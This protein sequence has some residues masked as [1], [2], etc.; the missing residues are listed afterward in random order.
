MYLSLAGTLVRVTGAR[1]RLAES[2]GEVFA[3]LLVPARRGRRASLLVRLAGGPAGITVG[4]GSDTVQAAGTGHAVAL[5]EH[6]LFSRWARRDSRHL[7]L[8]AAAVARRVRALLLVGEK[9][10][11][12][13]TLAAALVQRGL[14][15]GGDETVPLRLEDGRLA[16]LYRPLRFKPGGE[17]L[18]LLRGRRLRF[19]IYGG[20]AGRCPLWYARPLARA[21]GRGRYRLRG[22]VFLQRHPGRRCRLERLEPLPVLHRLLGAAYNLERVAQPAL[23]CLERLLPRCPAWRLEHGDAPRALKLLE[24]LAF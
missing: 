15:L 8:H 3:P 16:A 10:A 20:D 6:L 21:L 2:L 19:A 23:D 22:I 24:E 9:G 11:G 13:T 17:R 7:V 14:L 18:P 12:K 5:A 1:G 4:C